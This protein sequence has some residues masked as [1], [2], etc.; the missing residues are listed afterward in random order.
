MASHIAPISSRGGVL[1]RVATPAI[2][3]MTAPSGAQPLAQLHA[4]LIAHEAQRRLQGGEPL[5]RC[6]NLRQCAQ[7]ALAGTGRVEV[8]R[9][10][11]AHAA[12]LLDVVGERQRVRAGQIT[13]AEPRRVSEV[14]RIPP[15]DRPP[16]LVPEE[17]RRFAELLDERVEQPATT[18]EPF[19]RSPW[20]DARYS[21][22]V[23]LTKDIANG[24]SVI[25]AVRGA[26]DEHL[27][28]L[29]AGHLA[30]G[31]DEELSLR[32]ARH[33]AD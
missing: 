22:R 11:D 12:H 25:E 23:G 20:N 27:Q 19:A 14:L 18:E 7:Q 33:H 28:A 9:D 2:P 8:D 5:E 29:A 30:S 13:H 16:S 4:D 3:H 24:P 21:Q 31:D 10:L 1:P 17:Q 15:E 32:L 26:Q 6:S